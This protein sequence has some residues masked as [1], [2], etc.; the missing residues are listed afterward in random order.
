MSEHGEEPWNCI[1]IGNEGLTVHIGQVIR[2]LWIV[3]SYQL[4]EHG[5]IFLDHFR[6]VTHKQS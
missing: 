5:Q 4:L 6:V 1:E 2:Q 3:K